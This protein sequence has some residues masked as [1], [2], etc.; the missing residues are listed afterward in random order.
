V[1]ASVPTDSTSSRPASAWRYL[2]PPAWQFSIRELLLL[3]A[4][5]AAFLAWAGLYFQ[6]AQ[7]YRRTPIPQLVGDFEIIQ[8]VGRA[9]GQ[10]VLS[11]SSGGS[12]SSDP[13]RST[14]S[15]DPQITFPPARRGELMEGYQAELRGLL[16]AHADDVWGAGTNRDGLGLKAFEFTYEKGNSRGRVFVRSFDG[17]DEIELF[18]FVHEFDMRD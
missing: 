10:P 17:Q 2:L 7:P 12:G 13:Q 14:Y 1:D 5:V 11:Y 18:I 6:R 15:Y 9:L 3:T 8:K 4:A 16:E